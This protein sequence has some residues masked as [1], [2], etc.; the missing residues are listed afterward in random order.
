MALD[1]VRPL[2]LETPAEGGTED[3]SFPT[4]V[5][6]N[7]DYIQGKG[8]AIDNNTY[9]DKDGSGNMRFTDSVTG[10]KLLSELAQATGLTESS[11]LILD[12]LVHN[13]SENSYVEYNR[14]GGLINSII[15][16]TDSGKTQKIREWIYTRSGGLVTSE[17]IKQYN[18]IGTLIKTETR[19]ISRTGGLVISESVVVS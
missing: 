1:L 16:W 13:I 19:T 6:V 3:D 10:Q 4:E 5:D 12:Q 18:N 9:V 8:F 11:H 17:V 7:E 15:I 2:K 14:T